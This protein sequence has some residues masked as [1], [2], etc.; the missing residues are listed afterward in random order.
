MPTSSASL[1][2]Y[3]HPPPHPPLYASSGDMSSR[4][5]AYPPLSSA[6]QVSH[7]LE[8]R[9][10]LSSVTQDSPEEPPKAGVKRP[11]KS[12]KKT[13]GDGGEGDAS[14]RERVEDSGGIKSEKTAAKPKKRKSA[15]GIPKASKSESEGGHG[16]T[17]GVGHQN[18][19]DESIAEGI[20]KGGARMAKRKVS[21]AEPHSEKAPAAGLS[22]QHLTQRKRSSSS[23]M[24]VANLA[25][26]PH[27]GSS[28]R[29]RSSPASP[30]DHSAAKNAI[31]DNMEKLSCYCQSRYSDEFYIQCDACDEWFH[32]R[33]VGITEDEA[34]GVDKWF[35]RGCVASHGGVEFVWKPKCAR[36]GCEKRAKTSVGAADQDVRSSKYCSRECG[37]LVAEER[38]RAKQPAVRPKSLGAASLSNA[39]QLIIEADLADMELLRAKQAFKRRRKAVIRKL[40]ER[41][42][43]VAAAVEK[44]RQAT[45]DGVKVCGFD[46][47]IVGEWVVDT[48]RAAFE[49]RGERQNGE[50]DGTAE[51][52]AESS[53]DNMENGEIEGDGEMGIGETIC[54][55]TGKCSLHEG[56]EGAKLA[57]VNVDIEEQLVL[58]RKDRREARDVKLRILRRRA[59]AKAGLT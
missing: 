54:K 30:P 36:A 8:R 24:A 45:V 34:E 31:E 14:L 28:P 55:V 11:R 58:L 57:E 6:L 4:S 29:V 38:V 19:V 5:E 53:G 27:R 9:G 33:C 46:Q 56:W 32:G 48:D 12:S 35:C 50:G 15:N 49:T 44:G 7:A 13:S 59:L 16:A 23:T 10:S 37:M 17:G 3:R 18:S 25:G 40:E 2:A 47:R 42:R 39:K 26:S 41:G 20:V 52:K 51:R 43:R 21:K 22:E 1:A